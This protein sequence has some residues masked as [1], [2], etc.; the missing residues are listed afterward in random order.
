MDADP[1]KVN[2]GAGIGV[3]VTVFV[4]CSGFEDGTFG[5]ANVPGKNGFGVAGVVD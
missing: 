1:E 4:G 3:V 5:A 2:A